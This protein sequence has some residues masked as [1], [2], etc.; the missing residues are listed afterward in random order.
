MDEDL[1]GKRADA[2]LRRYTLNIGKIETCEVCNRFDRDLEGK[3]ADASVRGKKLKQTIMRHVRF[4][5]DV[6]WIGKEERG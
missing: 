3:R 1:E 2:I 6:M 4:V 5:T